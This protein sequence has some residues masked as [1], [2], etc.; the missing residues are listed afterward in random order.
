LVCG[1]RIRV[2][3]QQQSGTKN[4]QRTMENIRMQNGV[5][6]TIISENRITLALDFTD[7]IL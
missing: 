4:N 1:L 2:C 5:R 7:T 3:C 6:A